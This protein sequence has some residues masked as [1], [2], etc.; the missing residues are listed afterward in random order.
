[1]QLS[2]VLLVFLY[3][4]AMRACAQGSLQ[5]KQDLNVPY[6]DAGSTNNTTSFFFLLFFQIKF[7]DRYVSHYVV[8]SGNLNAAS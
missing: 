2:L 1:M 8:L 3:R 6:L 4:S 7:S 5:T